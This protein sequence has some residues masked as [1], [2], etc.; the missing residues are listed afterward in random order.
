LR[1]RVDNVTDRAF[2]ASAGGFPGAG[3]L[4]AGAPRTFVVSGTI[5]F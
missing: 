1:A 3:Y 5:D 4:V 2:W